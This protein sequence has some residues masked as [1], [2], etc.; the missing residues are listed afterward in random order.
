MTF[1][2]ADCVLIVG[3][4]SYISQALVDKIRHFKPQITFVTRTTSSITD[5]TPGRS[6]PLDLHSSESVE[7][8]L[9]ALSAQKFDY[10]YIFSGAVSGLEIDSSSIFETL[11]YYDAWAARLNF[12]I[13]RLHRNLNDSGTL[14]FISSRAAHRPSY[15]AHYSAVKASTEA[16][17]VSVAQKYPSK[18]FLVLA[19]SLIQDTRMY[20]AMSEEN[21]IE[22]KRRTNDSLL[23]LNEIVEQLIKM[24]VEKEQYL[25]GT[26][27]TL[28]RDW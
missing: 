6:F 14:I 21:I 19:P 28:G 16:L 8:L 27:A 24:S 5:L 25:N 3:A 17:I 12:L 23:T 13:S 18:R 9:L 4:G 10:I 2:K 22:H 7:N 1:S 15:D 20:Q 11:K 26:V